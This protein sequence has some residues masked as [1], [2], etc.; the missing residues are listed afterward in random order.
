MSHG[1]GQMHDKTLRVG[2]LM[3]G[4]TQW[5]GGY[6]YLR[7]LCGALIRY[8]SG[9][10]PVLFVPEDTEAALLE[11]FSEM[12]ADVVATP[13][14]GAGRKPLLFA[15][16][17]L[18]GRITRLEELFAQQRIDALFENSVYFGWRARLPVV[19]WLPDFQHRHLPRM[20]SPLAWLKREFGFRVVTASTRRVMLSSE[21]AKADCRRFYGVPE[22]RISV[23]SFAVEPPPIEPEYFEACLQRYQITPP[24][25]YLPNQLWRHK[26]HTVVIEALHRLQVEGVVTPPVICS[27]S[28]RDHRNIA[29]FDEVEELIESCGVSP[30]FRMIGMVPYKD[31][32]HLMAGACAV[33]NPSFFE[34]WSTTVEE[35]KALCI[36]LLLSDIPVHR[37]Q[38]KDHARFFDPSSPKALAEVLQSLHC[39]TSPSLVEDADNSERVQTYAREFAGMIRSLA[40]AA[41]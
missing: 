10:E 17:L 39:G 34:G 15:Q 36:P 18:L 24:Y 35:A 9:I 37:E 13:L 31:V 25:L 5:L 20:F 27:G 30:T 33:V 32:I 41:S 1:T 26:N 16:A 6:N 22:E 4:G 23:V 12:G 38:V 40:E 11:P 14:L 21:D 8:R 2:F 29:Y 7:N 3:L 19:T 28:T